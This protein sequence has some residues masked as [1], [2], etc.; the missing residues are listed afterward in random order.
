MLGNI[1]ITIFNEIFNENTYHP[2]DLEIINS[3]TGYSG[4]YMD[5][6]T[7]SNAS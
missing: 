5:Q 1:D 6:D 2:R 4:N 7:H 3:S